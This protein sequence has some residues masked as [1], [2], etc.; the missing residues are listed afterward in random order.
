MR[1][2]CLMLELRDSGE[3]I[4]AYELHHEPGNVWPEVIRGIKTSGISAM[5]IFR[6][7]TRLTMIMEVEDSFDPA[8]KAAND[9]S[10]PKIAEWERLMET[11]QDTQHI[12]EPTK[13]WRPATCIFD[14]SEHSV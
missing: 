7:G 8:E 4:E 11:F 9:A 12:D 3:L 5:R 1:V 13:K 10:N 2:L 6:E 14:L